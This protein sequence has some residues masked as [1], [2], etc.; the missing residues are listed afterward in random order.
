MKSSAKLQV[1]PACESPSVGVVGRGFRGGFRLVDGLSPALVTLGDASVLAARVAEFSPEHLVLEWPAGRLAQ[2]RQLS[3]A[4]LR[5]QGFE[6]LRFGVRLG[7]ANLRDRRGEVGLDVAPPTKGLA[8]A[9]LA[10]GNTLLRNRLA[11][12][13]GQRAPVQELIDFG[14]RPQLLD[15]LARNGFEGT[16][17]IGD[18]PIGRVTLR[19]TLED[20][21]AWRFTGPDTTGNVRIEVPGYNSLFVVEVS[22]LR[23]EGDLLYT[24]RPASALR[25]RH[26][27]L[28]RV[29]AS[30][31]LAVEFQHPIW[32]RLTVRRAV[33]EISAGGISF[34]TCTDED[35]LYPGLLAN[36]ACLYAGERVMTFMG[37][38]RSI[39]ERGITS[40]EY[41]GMRVMPESAE[42]DSTWQQILDEHLYPT[43]KKGAS[44]AAATW[45]LYRDAGYFNLSGKESSDFEKLQRAFDTVSRKL[46]Q[47]PHLGCH[48]VWVDSDKNVEAAL[49]MLKPYS[50]AWFGFQMAKVSGNTRKGV[51][52][53]FVLRDIH[54]HC[55]EHAQRDASLKWLIA[56]PQVKPVW[57]RLVHHDLPARYVESGQAAVVRFRAVEIACDGDAEAD[58]TPEYDVGVATEEETALLLRE[59]AR[60]RPKAYVE[61]LDFVPDRF[62]L[63]ELCE[64]WSLAGL[65]R[66]RSA[67][68]ARRSGK[69]VAAAVLESADEGTH[70]FR[71]LDLVRLFPLAPA[72]EEANAALLDAARA[73]FRSMDKASF[74]AFLEYDT[75]MPEAFTGT[76][77]DLGL[78]DYAV[79]SADLLP[80]LLEHVVEVTAPREPVVPAL[81]ASETRP[82]VRQ[83]QAT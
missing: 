44:W 78:A 5:I 51:L 60:T 46:D 39:S 48:V 41:C 71:L 24:S 27:A 83:A 54:L 62:Q 14:E 47:A 6:E 42:D 19:M 77:W 68:V 13:E 72:G 50:T 21:L 15:S 55:Y 53:R 30:D 33:R 7:L 45:D 11:T 26:R 29:D 16:V 79:L 28:R 9:L 25:L 70:L 76:T 23:C 56:I 37:E 43:T 4:R 18:Y 69:P 74:I 2:T 59:I 80:E 22:V 36:Q 73:W 67:L 66:R 32:P 3:V 58:R 52:G 57:S 17:R 40:R 75:P 63:T 31:G 65:G 81:A 12:V 8:R 35:L 20:G 1:V 64:D 34:A 49:S 82:F 10:R 61:A 38:V